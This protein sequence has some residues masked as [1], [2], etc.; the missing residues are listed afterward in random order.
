V[1]R[2]AGSELL[3]VDDNEGVLITLFRILRLRGYDALGALS[4]ED[5]L[6]VLRAEPARVRTA[7]ID[8]FL[9]G[10][11]GRTWRSG[12]PQITRE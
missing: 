9:P 7:A 6:R 4:G 5:A 10:M 12:S 11:S 2:K 3:V 8:L 1:E